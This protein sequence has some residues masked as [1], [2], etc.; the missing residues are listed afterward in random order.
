VGL[1]AGAI[2]FV[3]TAT[4]RAGAGSPSGDARSQTAHGGAWRHRVGRWILELR[5]EIPWPFNGERRELLAQRALSLPSPAYAIL[6][7][8]ISVGAWPER[9]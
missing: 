1:D 6:P 7:D 3:V 4:K 9:I 8:S 2:E 5:Q